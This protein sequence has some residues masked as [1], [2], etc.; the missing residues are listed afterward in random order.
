MTFKPKT[1][2]LGGLFKIPK[3]A[4]PA[5]PKMTGPKAAMPRM[6]A[7]KMTAKPPS[8]LRVGS[9]LRLN[10]LPLSKVRTGAGY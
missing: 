3:P 1:F 9:T 2:S 10:R 5:I 4:A 6:T 7:P 8:A